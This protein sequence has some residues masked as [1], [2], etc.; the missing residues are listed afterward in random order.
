LRKDLYAKE[1][2]NLDSLRQTLKREMLEQSK[3]KSGGEIVIKMDKGNENILINQLYIYKQ[4]NNYSKK[5]IEIEKR[6][7]LYEKCYFIISHLNETG[8]KSGFGGLMRV[9][10]GAV[11]LSILSIVVILIKE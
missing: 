8:K 10:I 3:Q 2:Q 5:I 7:P 11:T 6:I 9:I 4:I 1:I